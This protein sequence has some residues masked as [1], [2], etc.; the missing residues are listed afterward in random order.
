MIKSAKE[1]VAEANAG[2]T[3]MSAADAIA[4]RDADTVFVDVREPA[5]RARGTIPG[6]VGAPRGLLEFMADPSSPMHNAAIADDRKLVVFCA[7]GGRSALAAKTL[8]DMGYGDV[9]H[10][11]GGIGAWQAAGGPVEPGKD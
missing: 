10:I 3:K 8:R 7:S 1:L 9:S 2:V 6:S 4:Q 5:E 11:E